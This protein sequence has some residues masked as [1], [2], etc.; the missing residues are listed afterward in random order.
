MGSEMCIRDSLMEDF[1]KN[2]MTSARGMGRRVKHWDAWYALFGFEERSAC[3]L[4]ALHKAFR[5]IMVR[6]HPDRFEPRAL[7]HCAE[8]AST[9]ISA[10][11]EL[12]GEHSE[13]RDRKRGE[14]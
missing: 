14:L 12:I 11:Y 3:N 7:R 10:G 1:T 4:A 9:V 13:C 8:R 5:R 2:G 6:Y